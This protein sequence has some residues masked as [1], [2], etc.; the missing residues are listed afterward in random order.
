MKCAEFPKDIG[1]LLRRR[2]KKARQDKWRKRI[3]GL[4][5]RLGFH[6]WFVV[7]SNKCTAYKA[8][9]FSSTVN[10]P[11]MAKIEECRKC[12]AIRGVITDGIDYRVFPASFLLE[13]GF[14]L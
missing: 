10:I 3:Q 5:C 12:P 1:E 8:N 13:K 4:K 2:R 9:V 7:K 14:I 11:A 6:D